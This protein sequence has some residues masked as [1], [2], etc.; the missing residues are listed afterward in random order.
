[1]RAPYLDKN[2]TVMAGQ[3]RVF[4][5]DDPAIHVCSRRAMLQDIDGRDKP[6]MTTVNTIG[7]DEVTANFYFFPGAILESAGLAASGL[8][9]VSAGLSMR[10]ILAASRSFAT[11]SACA[12][13]VT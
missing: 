13:R 1:M 10:S 7:F 2:S 9:A 6:A 5:L 11:Y 4:A 8:A 3:K 12:L